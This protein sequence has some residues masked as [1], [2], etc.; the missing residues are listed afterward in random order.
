MIKKIQPCLLAMIIIL[1]PAD[2]LAAQGLGGKATVPVIVATV[3]EEPF[4][5]RV[6]ALGTLRANET[7]VLMATVTEKVTA[8][9][10]NDGARVEKG[11]ILI[12]MTRAEEKSELEAERA[13]V[14]EARQ[15]LDRIEAV[16]KAGAAPKSTL[17]QRRREY[18]TAKARLQGVQSRIGDRIVEAP[19]AGVLGLRDVS[20]GTVLQPGTRITTLDDD[21]VM[22]LDFSVPSVFLS[23]LKPGLAITATSRAFEGRKFTGTISSIESQID[24]VTRAIGVRALIPNDDR[25]L[26]PG[27]LMSVEILKNPR[28]AVMIPEEAIIPEGRKNSVFVV[29]QQD[30]KAI[31]RKRSVTLGGRRPGQ[32]EVTSGLAIGEIVVIQ[33]TLRI[34]DGSVVEVK[35]ES[36]VFKTGVKA[37]ER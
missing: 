18:E 37:E 31:A 32:V 22:K 27:L 3:Q 20:V 23:T 10:F 15:Q 8:I 14:D 35:K 26:R 7:V 11:D 28:R 4:E 24:P 13:T 25:S 19:F 5:D 33:G 16:V 12:E 29:T 36:D 21:S 9:N 2:L 1:V 17:D 30:N 6:E 34:S